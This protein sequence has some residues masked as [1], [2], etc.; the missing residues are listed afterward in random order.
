MKTI[1]AN[2]KVSHGDTLN[3][4]ADAPE[5]DITVVNCPTPPRIVT[6]R[7]R[8]SNKLMRVARVIAAMHPGATVNNTGGIIIPHPTRKNEWR[9]ILLN[10]ADYPDD[11]GET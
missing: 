2:A 5:M 8:P 10:W 6:G 1:N 7:P 3:I 4:T 11:E 9:C